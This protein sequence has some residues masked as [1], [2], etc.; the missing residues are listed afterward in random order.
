MSPQ[1]RSVVIR[2]FFK[3]VMYTLLATILSVIGYVTVTV[4]TGLALPDWA[5]A[6]ATV[7]VSGLA[8]AIHKSVNWQ[9]AGVEAPPVPDAPALQMPNIEETP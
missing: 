9:E 2:R 5:I 7:V 1:K 3:V 4:L 8:A 6:V